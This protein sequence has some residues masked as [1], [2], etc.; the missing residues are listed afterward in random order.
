MSEIN[1]TVVGNITKNP[2]I[3]TTH[4]GKLVTRLRVASTRKRHIDGQWV[5]AEKAYIDVDCW[6][7]LAQNVVNT[8]G[9]GD[10]I[11]AEGR[12]RTDEWQDEEGNK[13]SFT[14]VVADS[15][16][17]DLRFATAVITRNKTSGSRTAEAERRAREAEE[18]G[19]G[20][21]H[22][23]GDGQSR[24][25]GEAGEVKA[26]FPEDAKVPDMA[27][28]DTESADVAVSD[29]AASGM[30]ATDLGTADTEAPEAEVAEMAS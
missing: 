10:R 18:M 6:E 16:G 24:G 5:D 19:Q 7:H 28:A 30:D 11:I 17:A 2:E 9:K 29:M 23:G 21:G 27:A 25:S 20:G 15:V 13:R 3:K 14:K 8:F 1:V 4:G 22:A 26:F 12:L